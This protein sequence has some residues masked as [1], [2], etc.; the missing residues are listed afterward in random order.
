MSINKCAVH[1][2]DRS[3]CSWLEFHACGVTKAVERL[4]P[5][6]KKMIMK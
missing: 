5:G 2:S 6:N 1:E 4:E 3:V